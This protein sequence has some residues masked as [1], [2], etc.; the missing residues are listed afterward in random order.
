MKTWD[1]TI[2]RFVCFG[3]IAAGSRTFALTQDDGNID[4]NSESPESVVILER[5]L[6]AELRP[7]TRA[8]LHFRRARSFLAAV[9]YRCGALEDAGAA[10]DN[11]DAFANSLMG[12]SRL[13]IFVGRRNGVGGLTESSKCCVME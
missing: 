5:L 8:K 1:A 7:A 13:S 2:G 4:P 10:Q 6:Q 9:L 12:F 11:V 3:R